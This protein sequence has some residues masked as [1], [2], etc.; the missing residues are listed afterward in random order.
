MH[1]FS[2][3]FFLLVAPVVSS[4]LPTNVPHGS[5]K[6]IHPFYVS[7]TQ[8]EEN[9]KENIL[10]I[11]CKIF[12]D[13]FEHALRMHYSNKVD[14]L[15]GDKAVM[16]PLVSD[17]ISKHLSISIDGKTK[18]LQF[19]GFEKNEEAVECYF[20]INNPEIKNE[21]SVLNN[22]LFEYKKEQINIVHVT[23][24]GKRKSSQF[25]NPDARKIFSF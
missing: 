9:S 21:V 8:I 14:L 10:E 12:V 20:Q 24:R 17:Y 19:V 3:L 7:V 1:A 16:N 15:N 5:G 22:I 6:N 18:A 13:D 4:N 23:V 25:I 2:L 11:S